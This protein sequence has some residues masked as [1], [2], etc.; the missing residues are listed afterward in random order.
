MYLPGSLQRGGEQREGN[1]V[2]RCLR[3]VVLPPASIVAIPPMAVMYPAARYIV[4]M[5]RRRRYPS[6]RHPRV[7]ISTPVVVTRSPNVSGSR[8]RRRCFYDRRR[9]TH[10]H[11]KMYFSGSNAYGQ[12]ATDEAGDQSFANHGIT[13][14]PWQKMSRL[15]RFSSPP[16]SN[17]EEGMCDAA[18]AWE[19]LRPVSLFTFASFH[20]TFSA[21]LQPT[22]NVLISA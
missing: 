11:V 19:Q 14:L 5:V 1:P 20:G 10:S 12:S 7:G 9:G 17:R 6:A 4:M 16:G 13:P 15:F 2:S 8:H 18:N 22:H 3:G 21:A